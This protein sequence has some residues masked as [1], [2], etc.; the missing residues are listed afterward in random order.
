MP[1]R[2]LTKSIRYDS[3]KAIK[4]K[5]RCDIRRSVGRGSK[6][7]AG[8]SWRSVPARNRKLNLRLVHDSFDSLFPLFHDQSRL[9]FSS[10]AM[11]NLFISWKILTK[12]KNCLMRI[13]SRFWFEFFFRDFSVIK[14]E[15][16]IKNWIYSESKISIYNLRGLISTLYLKTFGSFFWRTIWQNKK[17]NS[18]KS[19][20]TQTTYMII[21]RIRNFWNFDSFTRGQILKIGYFSKKIYKL[22]NFRNLIILWIC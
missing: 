1:Y 22:K 20:N 4:L 8:V 3:S 19:L 16:Q 9:L 2:R 11:F 7:G 15:L 5:K 13:S 6:T 14:L 12:Q 21:Y 18:K 17:L 10:E